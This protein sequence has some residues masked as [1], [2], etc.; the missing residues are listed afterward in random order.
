MIFSLLSLI[1]IIYAFKNIRK[2]Y[3]W[4]LLLDTIW[5]PSAK[6]VEINSFPSIPLYLVVPL[7]FFIAYIFFM[8]KM[9]KKGIFHLHYRYFWYLYRDF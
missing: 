7:L 6:I 1:L 8:I 4:Y 9:M 2:A 5:L 3:C